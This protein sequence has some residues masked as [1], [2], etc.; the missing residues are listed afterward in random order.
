[1]PIMNW[2]K[3][4]D[5]GVKAMND[6]HHG[7]L[8][9]MNQIYDAH[10]VGKQGA[11]INA[12]VAKLGEACTEHFAHEEA[13]MQR[14]GYPG[15]TNHK[16]LHTS[17]LTRYGDFAARIRAAGGIASDDFFQFLKFWLSSHI[18]G[19]DTKYAAHATS[20]GR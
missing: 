17:L 18:K 16:A 19:I 4:L 15:F 9:I 11:T 2:D 8:D 13:Y 12:L 6:E 14:I 7:L 10:A 5:I 1:M 3:S 20:V